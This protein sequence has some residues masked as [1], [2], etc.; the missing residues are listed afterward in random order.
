MS[1]GKKTLPEENESKKCKAVFAP[2]L[3]LTKKNAGK[4]GDGFG[5]SVAQRRSGPSFV[6][7]R[8]RLMPRRSCRETQPLDGAKAPL[9]SKCKAQETRGR[10]LVYP[11]GFIASKNKK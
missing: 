7:K 3:C 11:Y 1:G 4:S 6:E 5:A 2:G 10:S 8:R 9:E